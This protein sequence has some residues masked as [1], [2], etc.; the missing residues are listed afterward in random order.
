MEESDYLYNFLK[1]KGAPQAIELLGSSEQSAELQL[2]YSGK[3]EVYHATPQFNDQLG[4]KEWIVR[5]PYIVERTAYRQIADIP[6]GR[7]GI[8]EIF[9][10]REVLGGELRAA[11]T[12]VIAP[13]FVPTPKPVARR[14]KNTR[15]SGAE[16]GASTT[17][18]SPS[19]F[20][21]QAIAETRGLK[22]KAASSP[23]AG[24]AIIVNDSKP[25]SSLMDKSD[26][27]TRKIE[28]PSIAPEKR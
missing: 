21:Q 23:A 28:T 11:Q 8:F 4:A 24:P 22:P 2:F 14:V 13:A 26:T 25:F 20:D 10:R 16:G 27:S 15:G 5:G 1:E 19:N 12:R 3:Q 7:G 6:A 9:G 17:T 18:T